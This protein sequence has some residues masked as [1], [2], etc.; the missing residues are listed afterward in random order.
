MNAALFV[1][2]TGGIDLPLVCSPSQVAPLLGRS[3]HAIRD[4]CMAGIIPTL[5]RA[6]G[7]GELGRS[8]APLVASTTGR[9]PAASPDRSLPS[10]RPWPRPW[11]RAGASRLPPTAPKPPAGSA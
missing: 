9:R 1:R 3:D 4:D 11:P 8:H 5:P 6:G 7:S 10:P 2:A